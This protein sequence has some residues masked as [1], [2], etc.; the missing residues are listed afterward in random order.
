MAKRLYIPLPDMEA[1]RCIVQK[2]MSQQSH[3]LT[4]TDISHIGELTAG[5]SGSDMANL[6]R[7]AAMGPIRSI[8]AAAMLEEDAAIASVKLEDVR[9]VTLAD[10]E[11]AT[12]QV[13]ASVH[14]RD[15]LQYVE[16]NR[17]F[18]SA[19]IVPNT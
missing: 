2:L 3:T 1:R 17:E 16:W 5:Y 8:S 11:F 19:G 4:D 6:C 12:T 18:G 15:L 7:E 13:R 10:F 14:E 9:P